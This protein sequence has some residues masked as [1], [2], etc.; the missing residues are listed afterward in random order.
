ML[1]TV[2]GAVREPCVHEIAIG[3]PVGHYGSFARAVVFDC[4]RRGPR[5]RALLASALAWP[6][7]RPS[8][9]P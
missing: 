1:V 5:S 9:L 7:T 3:T 2:L 8:R 4:G 6:G